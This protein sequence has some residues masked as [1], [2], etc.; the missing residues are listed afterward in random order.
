MPRPVVCSGLVLVLGVLCLF[1]SPASA[2]GRKRQVLDA[3]KPVS[4]PRVEQAS[5]SVQTDELGPTLDAV[6]QVLRHATFTRL[7]AR[8]SLESAEVQGGKVRLRGVKIENLRLGVQLRA[9]GARA[10]A[11]HFGRSV[12]PG[13]PLKPLFEIVRLGLFTD[14]EVGLFL[15]ELSLEA[16]DLDAEELEI[17]GALVAAGVQ[18]TPHASRPDAA[19]LDKFL[20]A[21]R[22]LAFNRARLEAGLEHLKARRID[23]RLQ[24]LGLDELK[25]GLSLGRAETAF[26][27]K[28]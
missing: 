12:G 10:L 23:A 6:L 28:K 8:I 24:G 18:T 27:V 17:E 25:I 1:A 3:P 13:S 2:Q 9:D 26:P 4:A 22:L 5:A 21:V 7:D 11:E 15:R 20:E 19:T 14:I 16:L